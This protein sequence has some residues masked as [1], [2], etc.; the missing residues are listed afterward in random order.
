MPLICIDYMLQDTKLNC[1]IEHC[2]IR[3]LPVEHFLWKTVK[4]FLR[5][6]K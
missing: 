4:P 1:F 2:G 3:L 5:R 6:L